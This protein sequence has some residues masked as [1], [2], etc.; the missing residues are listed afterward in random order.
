MGGFAQTVRFKIIL[1]LGACLILMMANGLSGINGLARLNSNMRDSYT[2]AVLPVAQ[3]SDARASS[4]NIR[5]RLRRIEVTRSPEDV[6]QS[7]PDI[8]GDLATIE[9]QWSA[10]YP[11][12][13]SSEQ[14]RVVAD[15]IAASH[16][17]RS[18]SMG[19]PPRTGPCGR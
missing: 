14:E 19:M 3:L 11:S 10:Y 18:R 17:R 7:S 12:G 16:R 8:Q 15:Q 13:V 6:A 2:G 5:A 4:L 9:S 1:S